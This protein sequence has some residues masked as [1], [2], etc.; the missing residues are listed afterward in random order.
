MATI[1]ISGG[2]GY[3]GTQLTINLLKKNNVIIYDKF[4]F[5]WLIKNKNKIS[6]NHRLSFIKKDI[7]KVNKNDF[8]NIDIVC[9]LAAIANDPS[10]ELNTKITWKVNYYSRLK[11][12]KIAKQSGVKRY[13]FNSSCSI[14]GFNENITHENSE[15]NPISTYAKAV[16]KAEKEIYKLKNKKFKINILRN[17]SL[18]GYSNEMR[19]DLAIN[20]FVYN[21]IHNLPLLVDGNGLQFRPFISVNDI[22]KVYDFIINKK[23]KLP[24]FICNLVAFNSSITNIAF[25]ILNILKTKSKIQFKENFADNRNYK[26]KSIYFKDLFGAKFIFSKFN[27]EVLELKNFLKKNKIKKN[28]RTIRLKFYKKNIRKLLT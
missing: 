8:N 16:L 18:Y 5:P 17:S 20:N 14:Y 23:K 1:L 12:A 28:L 9:D 15:P 6:N 4:Y 3:L 7:S 13:I 19:M 10:C 26:I 24:S 2:G 11:F 22:V 25:K 21:A 27:K